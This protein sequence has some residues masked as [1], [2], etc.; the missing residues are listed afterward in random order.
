MSFQPSDTPSVLPTDVP[1]IS[2]QPSFSPSISL[3]PSMDRE[4]LISTTSGSNAGAFGCMFTV[5]PKRAIIVE[6]FFIVTFG[7]TATFTVHV[8]SRLGE[9]SGVPSD[10]SAWTK[11]GQQTFT[12]TNQNP[13]KVSAQV[14]SSVT[15]YS[16]QTQS[17]Y[18]AFEGHYFKV[19]GETM[20][21]VSENNDVS[22]YT[23]LR[24]VSLYLDSTL[25]AFLQLE[26]PT[27]MLI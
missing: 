6:T 9:W 25:L 20:G 16:G 7:Q 11:L 15:I 21:T 27:H 12:A 10:A 22:L 3:A 26:H 17:F 24:K 14:F 13:V 18:I 2:M 23:G 5:V 4:S 1:S 19:K 8:F